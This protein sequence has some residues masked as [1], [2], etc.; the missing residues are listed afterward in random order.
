MTHQAGGSLFSNDGKVATVN[1]PAAAT[2]LQTWA[3][4]AHVWKIYDPSL[5]PASGG[6]DLFGNGTAA[7]TT[8]GG[9][10]EVRVLQQD[11]PQTYKHYTA[12]P[13]P[14][15]ATRPNTGADLYGW[16]LSPPN[17][18]QSR[19][20]AGKFARFLADNGATY[21]RGPGLW[22]GDNAT[23]KGWATRVFPHWEFSKAA[24]RSGVFPPPLT[25]FTQITD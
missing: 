14:R 23:L 19:G 18:S 9:T 10:F 13:S 7:M 12:G 25:H 8:Y 17:P 1:S 24:Y 3:D 22:L 20:G 21:F 5:S 6:V 16:G 4:F 2:A 11:F 15:F